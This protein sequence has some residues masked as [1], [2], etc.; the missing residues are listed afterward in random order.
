LYAKLRNEHP[1]YTKESLDILKHSPKEIS[2]RKAVNELGYHPR[3]LEET[4]RDTF[5]WY[6]QEDLL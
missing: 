3:P 6:K 5:E 4:L 2:S 1:L